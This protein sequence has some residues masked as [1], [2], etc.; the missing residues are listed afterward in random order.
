VDNTTME[1]VDI[2]FKSMVDES[3]GVA[4]NWTYSCDAQTHSLNVVSRVE[5]VDLELKITND[6]MS[7]R[8]KIGRCEF[9]NIDQRKDF[10]SA[11]LK[12]D[13]MHLGIQVPSS[14]EGLL[15]IQV[16]QLD[17]ACLEGFSPKGQKTFLDKLLWYKR[18]Y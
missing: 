11:Q 12:N 15:Q 8:I 3:S 9:S 14:R 6:K 13:Q 18:S 2:A 4:T 7:G 10:W 1:L 5:P 17:P 16:H